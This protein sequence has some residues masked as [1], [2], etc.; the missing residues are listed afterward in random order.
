MA[1]MYF[2]LQTMIYPLSLVLA[3]A[4][5]AWVHT[6]TDEI[7]VVFAI[8]GV[9]GIGL[10]LFFPRRFVLSGIVLGLAPTTAELLVRFEMARAPWHP[11]PVANLPLI[12]LICLLPPT[13]GA[14]FGW[15][16]RRGGT[17]THPLS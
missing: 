13:L 11:T 15:L 16:L 17:A 4:L 12:A 6:H 8:L 1:A 2:I 14:T 3:F 10:G 5:T 9:L 7:P